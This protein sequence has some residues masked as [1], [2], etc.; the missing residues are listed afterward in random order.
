MSASWA[1]AL[2]ERPLS[3]ELVS[4]GAKF[5]VLEAQKTLGEVS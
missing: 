1:P 3:I 5:I 2:L 4:S